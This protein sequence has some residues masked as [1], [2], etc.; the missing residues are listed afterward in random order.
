MSAADV[1][2]AGP[3]RC[4]RVDQLCRRSPEQRRK[5]GS[6]PEMMGRIKARK[7][8]DAGSPSPGMRDDGD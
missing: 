8:S 7:K 6:S 1:G 2:G 4:R 3:G 5:R